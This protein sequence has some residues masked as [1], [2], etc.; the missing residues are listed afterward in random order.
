MKIA[1]V[2]V[3]S[4]APGKSVKE[5][6]RCFLIK[7]IGNDNAYCIKVSKAIKSEQKNEL[8]SCIDFIPRY[9]KVWI[10][11]ESKKRKDVR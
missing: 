7:N 4:L 3:P 9:G 6:K 11:G 5:S 10:K 8:I 1:D 2:I